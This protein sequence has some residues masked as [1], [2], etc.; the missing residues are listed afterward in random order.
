[1]PVFIQMRLAAIRL[2]RALRRSILNERSLWEIGVDEE[3]CPFV[4][5]G[6]FR[7]VIV[8]RAVRLFD[9]LHVYS[10]D[11]EVWLPLWWRLRLRNAVRL[12]IAENALEMFES[13]GLEASLDEEAT[14]AR[15]SARRGRRKQT[16]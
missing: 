8:P 13:S 15:R 16:A 3:N 1:M 11:A 9:A 4:A 10:G 12:V 2:A 14:R 6:P 5:A 7:I